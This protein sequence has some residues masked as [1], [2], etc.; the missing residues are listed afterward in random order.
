MIAVEPD[1]RPDAAATYEK[2][3]GIRSRL[4]SV[5]C[6]WRLKKREEGV[7]VGI[8]FDVFTAVKLAARLPRKPIACIDKHLRK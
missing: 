7:I 3:K 6:E 4:S 8:F 5:K 1:V 2:W